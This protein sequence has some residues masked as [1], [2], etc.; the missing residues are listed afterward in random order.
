MQIVEL[1]LH[2]TP[3]SS[4]H[5]RCTGY[6]LKLTKNTEIHTS[7]W[8]SLHLVDSLMLYVTVSAK[9]QLVRTIKKYIY[10]FTQ[11][12][13]LAVSKEWI[14]KVSTFCGV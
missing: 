11:L 5:I 2:A 1:V 8:N 10:I 14:T 9:T 7:T 6:V 4:A 12:Y 13:L 3:S